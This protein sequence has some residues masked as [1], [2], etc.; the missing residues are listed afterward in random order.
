MYAVGGNTFFRAADFTYRLAQHNQ[1]GGMVAGGLF[2]KASSPEFQAPAQ[3]VAFHLIAQQRMNFINHRPV[4]K[5]A[6]GKTSCCPAIMLG[7]NKVAVVTAPDGSEATNPAGW[8]KGVRG[9]A[10][11][12]SATNRE[13][14]R[15]PGREVRQHDFDSDF[16]KLSHNFNGQHGRAVKFPGN[17]ERG[18]HQ[19][20]WSH[21]SAD[22]SRANFLTIGNGVNLPESRRVCH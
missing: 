16:A 13:A 2:H 22:P 9:N 10:F 20:S 3:P 11:E 7:M 21:A 5:Q 18:C 1:F 4:K 14:T 17:W 6:G 19:Y 12:F 15:W 8:G